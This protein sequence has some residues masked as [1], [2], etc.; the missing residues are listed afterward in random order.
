LR[1][2]PE[3]SNNDAWF[4]THSPAFGLAHTHA[5]RRIQLAAVAPEAWSILQPGRQGQPDG[6]V[7][8]ED[9]PVEAE[10]QAD[11]ADFGETEEA[12]WKVRIQS[13]ELYHRSL[14]LQGR[15]PSR[16]RRALNLGRVMQV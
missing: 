14:D 16:Q 15:M 5:A 10:F 6:G 2:T 3:K 1:S 13:S 11:T 9:Q 12:H 4:L 7:M 8:F